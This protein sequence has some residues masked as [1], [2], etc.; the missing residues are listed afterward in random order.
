MALARNLVSLYLA[1]SA[2]VA[3]TPAVAESGGFKNEVLEGIRTLCINPDTVRELNKME[4]VM[5]EL[6]D[7]NKKLFQMMHPEKDYYAP[8]KKPGLMV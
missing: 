2:V 4:G 3:I 1:A 6:C 8:P 5:P 7:K